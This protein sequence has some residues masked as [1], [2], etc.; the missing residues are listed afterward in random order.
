MEAALQ[1]LP[2]YVLSAFLVFCRVGTCLMLVPAVGSARVPL[3]VRLMLCLGVS[4]AVSAALGEF[5]VLRKGAP[6]LGA[7]AA[8]VAVETG[9]GLFIGVMV[10]F[11]FSM[12]E[13]MADAA[14]N[15]IGIA[16]MQASPEDSEMVPALASLVTIA[17][18]ALFVMTDQ[19]LEVLRALVQSYDVMA[20]G[21]TLDQKTQLAN[22]LSA[23]ASASLIA[24]QVCSPFL[25]FG[26]VVN[27]AFGVLNR[28]APQIPVYFLSFP[29]LIGGGLMLLYFL[30]DELLSI[31]MGRFSDWLAAGS[32]P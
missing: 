15:A 6:A 7:L 22:V 16:S 19:H 9:K 24:L 32:Y 17:A 21:A 28:L 8:L 27:F 20:F 11:F 4:A 5:E 13:F 10:R 30:S 29:F 25:V 12:L 14:A 23:L 26:V 18:S 1:V 3:Q 31:F 2:G